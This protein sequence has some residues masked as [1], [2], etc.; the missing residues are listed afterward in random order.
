VFQLPLILDSA[1]EDV[2]TTNFYSG[3]NSLYRFG[4]AGCSKRDRNRWQHL[5]DDCDIALASDER[6][7][8]GAS[9]IAQRSEEIYALAN[10]ELPPRD[11]MDLDGP[12]VCQACQV[13]FSD[14][15]SIREHFD[16]QHG[17]T[18]V[19]PTREKG[20]SKA[21]SPLKLNDDVVRPGKLQ[22]GV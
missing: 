15:H 14:G 1:T 8:A 9:M 12:L 22:K 7:K 18:F 5:C 16:T 11:D 21:S 2:L 19:M 3:V 4:C 6:V 17:A 13:E 10:P 20:K